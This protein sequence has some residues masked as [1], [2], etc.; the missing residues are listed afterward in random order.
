MVGPVVAETEDE[1]RRLF[2]VRKQAAHVEP[3]VDALR[4]YLDDLVALQNL[5]RR[6]GDMLVEVVQELARP[7]R[8]AM[9]RR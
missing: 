5:G 4:A 6:T 1:V 8:A 2:P 7:P 9:T 3:L